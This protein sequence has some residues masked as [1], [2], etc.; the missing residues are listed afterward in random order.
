MKPFVN[1]FLGL[2]VVCVAAD[3]A[4]AEKPRK[5]AK[6]ERTGS[7]NASMRT[8]QRTG[9]AMAEKTGRPTSPEKAP[10]KAESPDDLRN[11]LEG[12]ERRLDA[13]VE[14]FSAALTKLRDAERAAERSGRAKSVA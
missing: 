5:A 2:L 4:A 7:S 9:D 8:Q 3:V 11:A 13:E 6:P 14:R 1:T 12:V 10:G